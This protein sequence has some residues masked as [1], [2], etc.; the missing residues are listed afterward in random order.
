MGRTSPARR[1]AVLRGRPDRQ[2]LGGAVGC[3]IPHTNYGIRLRAFL[4]FDD[5]E[6]DLIAFFER[7]VP[8]QLNC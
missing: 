2:R 7:L 5:V 1:A 6:L 3:S 8:V 4:A